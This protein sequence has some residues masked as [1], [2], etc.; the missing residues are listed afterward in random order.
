MTSLV[1]VAVGLLL[2]IGHLYPAYKVPTSPPQ[3]KVD[4]FSAIEH[5]CG[6]L[7]TGCFLVVKQA[8]HRHGVVVLRKKVARNNYKR[9]VV[10]IHELVHW[11]QFKNGYDFSKRSVRECLERE[12]TYA[13]SIVVHHELIDPYYAA[14]GNTC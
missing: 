12:A 3:I 9:K 11:V 10:L 8:H 4:G 2:S 13:E 5:D 7:V 6:R 14:R 1:K